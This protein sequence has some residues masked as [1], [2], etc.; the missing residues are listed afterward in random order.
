MTAAAQLESYI[1]LA[2]MSAVYCAVGFSLIKRVEAAALEK[3]FG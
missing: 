3:I 2:A 1:R